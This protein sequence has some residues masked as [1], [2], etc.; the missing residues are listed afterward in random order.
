MQYGLGS[1]V[2]HSCEKGLR[3]GGGPSFVLSQSLRH[4]GS[5]DFCG[6]A[7][8]A[9]GEEGAG[10]V[11]WPHAIHQRAPQAD[12]HCTN[13][14][15]GRPF[16]WGEGVDTALW[17]PY[18]PPERAQLTGP[19]K[20]YRDCARDP[21]VTQT[22]DSAKNENGIFGISASR[23]FS[24]HLPWIWGGGVRRLRRQSS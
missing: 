23:G 21:E 11:E 17:L 1:H 14:R 15:G 2:C 13:H 22:Q 20:S 7:S 6:L 10:G 9:I 18:P 12:G 24:H 3:C 5:R 16:G 8:F 19:P 4:E